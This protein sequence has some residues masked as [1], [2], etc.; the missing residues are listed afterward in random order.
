MPPSYLPT[1]QPGYYPPSAPYPSPLPSSPFPDAYQPSAVFTGVASFLGPAAYC[2]GSALDGYGTYD[3]ATSMS[4]TFKAASTP[5]A[6]QVFVVVGGSGLPCADEFTGLPLPFAVA[7]VVDEG[8]ERF[9]VA[10]PVT[11]LLQYVTSTKLQDENNVK[12]AYSFVGVDASNGP[13]GSLAAIKSST[14]AIR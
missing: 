5:S 6:I 12:A 9:A 3:M 2:Q 1:Y 11:R 7:G 14:A 10:S 4:G 13:T 8:S